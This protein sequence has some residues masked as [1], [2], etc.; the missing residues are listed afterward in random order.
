LAVGE[1]AISKWQLAIS[2]GG[3]NFVLEIRW[4]SAE[5]ESVL[6]TGDG[7]EHRLYDRRLFILCFVDSSFSRDEF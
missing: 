4:S 6:I 1:S 3:N 7:V 5:R 2:G